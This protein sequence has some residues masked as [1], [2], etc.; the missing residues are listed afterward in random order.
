MPDKEDL[1]YIGSQLTVKINVDDLVYELIGEISS[2][3]EASDAIFE[4]YLVS[5]QGMA[6]TK[7]MGRKSK[8]PPNPFVSAGSL[9][10]A[11]GRTSR[12]G[13]ATR[14]SPAKRPILPSFSSD[15]D[16]DSGGSSRSKRSRRDKPAAQNRGEPSQK[17]PS[18][19]PP[20]PVKNI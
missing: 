12:S 5:P 13:M 16:P 20:A 15:E 17:G 4:Q 8:T 10:L 2:D 7:Q 3:E 1:H 19:K 14:M 6:R 18:K 9:P 11:L